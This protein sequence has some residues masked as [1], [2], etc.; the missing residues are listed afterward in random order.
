MLHRNSLLLIDEV[1]VPSSERDN[2]PQRS[3]LQF[4]SA[5][6][7]VVVM[8]IAGKPSLNWP[9]PTM[10]AYCNVNFP[11]QLS[12][13]RMRNPL[14]LILTRPPGGVLPTNCSDCEPLNT[15]SL[16]RFN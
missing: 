2:W 11:V 15:R 10:S 7:E 5:N 6:G 8:S 9:R 13:L 16:V 12:E 1:A 4:S 3:M 14:P